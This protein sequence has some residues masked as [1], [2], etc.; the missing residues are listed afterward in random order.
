M[1]DAPSGWTAS[2]AERELR[3]WEEGQSALHDTIEVRHG[4]VVAGHAGTWAEPQDA[5]SYD[6]AI[7]HLTEGA[8]VRWT[9]DHG[10]ETPADAA[11]RE[12]ARV[13]EEAAAWAAVERA[14][15]A[16]EPARYDGG[17]QSI[18]PYGINSP[19]AG[20]DRGMGIER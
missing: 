16:A 17:A 5:A 15:V 1:N 14:E 19:Y 4:G 20:H 10:I 18:S 8:P 13:H 7:A 2:I 11:A 3:P 12:A 6:A 9:D